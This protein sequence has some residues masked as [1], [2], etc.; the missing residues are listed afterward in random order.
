MDVH[1]HV[2]M[3]PVVDMLVA[4]VWW[5]ERRGQEICSRFPSLVNRK[6]MEVAAH[7]FVFLRPGHLLLDVGNLFENAHGDVY[8]VSGQLSASTESAATLNVPL[9][10]QRQLAPRESSQMHHRLLRSPGWVSRRAGRDL[11]RS[12]SCR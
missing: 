2:Y 12:C 4:G 5:E 8:Q 1:A 7:R 10:V 3:V 11:A 9:Y 6:G